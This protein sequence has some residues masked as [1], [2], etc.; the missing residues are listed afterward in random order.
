[1]TQTWTEKELLGCLRSILKMARTF[2]TLACPILAVSCLLAQW[3]NRL[4][5][6]DLNHLKSLGPNEPWIM[7]EAGNAC[8]AGSERSPV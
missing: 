3:S 5:C 6:D 7:K 4:L 8:M 2:Q 1:M